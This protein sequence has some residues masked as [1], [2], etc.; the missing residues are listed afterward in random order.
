MTESD[1]GVGLESNLRWF[2]G[3]AALPLPPCTNLKYNRINHNNYALGPYV[4]AVLFDSCF[5]SC[6]CW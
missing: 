6:E 2:G 4:C 5:C 1:V 3:N